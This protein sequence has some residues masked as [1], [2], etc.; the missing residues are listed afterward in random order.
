MTRIF[1]MIR[2][3]KTKLIGKM[4]VLALAASVAGGCTAPRTGVYFQSTK[5]DGKDNIWGGLAY[6]GIMECPFVLPTI[7]Y[8]PM[9][10]IGYSLDHYVFSPIYDVFNLPFDF[11]LR[12]TGPHIRVVDTSGRPIPRAHV[13]APVATG[14]GLFNFSGETDE[15]GLFYVPLSWRNSTLGRGEV[16][17]DG[18]V[19]TPMDSPRWLRHHSWGTSWQR[20][21]DGDIQHEVVMLRNGEMLAPVVKSVVLDTDRCGIHDLDIVE[22][23]WC[24]P[25]GKGRHDDIHMVFDG[26]RNPKDW[27]DFHAHLSVEF[28]NCAD[29]FYRRTA[30]TTSS[31]RYDYVAST[32]AAFEKAFDLR[33]ARVMNAVTNRMEFAK[34]DYL[35]YRVR[36]QT[37]EL[38]QVTHAHYGRIGEGVSQQIGLSMRSWFNVK[39]N[40]TNLEDARTW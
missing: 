3:M 17:A 29:G 11:Y 39:D 31:Y 16:T 18:F 23:D 30:D 10:G 19:T 4:L 14:V 13:N 38:G 12:N 7:V 6:V 21:K 34:D 36:T 37:N 28:P 40:D 35:V 1:I 25:Y 9:A 20:T 2:L 15:R 8:L 32:N 27:Y 33:Y 26:W 22:G 5:S 24:P